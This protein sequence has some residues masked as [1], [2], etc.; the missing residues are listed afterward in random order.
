MT[1]SQVSSRSRPCPSRVAK[2]SDGFMNPSPLTTDLQSL[3][4]VAPSCQARH[5]LLSR[6]IPA[7]CMAS[8][9]R[10]ISSTAPSSGARRIAGSASF[11]GAVSSATTF[12]GGALEVGGDVT[13]E[14]SAFHLTGTNLVLNGAT[15]QNVVTNGAGPA[16]T[17]AAI[18][19][20]DRV[21][22][23]GGGR[24]FEPRAVFTSIKLLSLLTA[25]AALV[26]AVNT[27]SNPTSSAVAIPA[28]HS[29]LTL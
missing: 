22:L 17:Q 10:S 4:G 20:L 6:A 16:P 5:R 2:G 3:R 11:T 1:I 29:R 13:G 8:S 25:L 23:E 28:R 24:L 18:D 19:T 26:T 14:G 12:I 27:V 7:R 21:S 9:T 15:L